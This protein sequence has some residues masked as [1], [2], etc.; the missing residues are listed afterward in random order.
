MGW[1]HRAGGHAAFSKLPVFTTT[2]LSWPR[3]PAG[4]CYKQQAHGSHLYLELDS[5]DAKA[6]APLPGKYAVR[7][8]YRA[9]VETYYALGHT[10]WACVCRPTLVQVLGFLERICRV[11][12]SHFHFLH[13]LLAPSP[14]SS[15]FFPFWV[16]VSC[17]RVHSL[18]YVVPWSFPAFLFW[19]TWDEM[20]IELVPKESTHSCAYPFM[21]S[22]QFG[23][24][25]I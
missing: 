12:L 8:R 6:Y 10:A 13:C 15:C 1:L 14:D 4:K 21:H 18:W 17:F 11:V 19:C 2:F 24:L 3:R 22:R 16:L 23:A 25:G 7:L 5:F 20:V 9:N